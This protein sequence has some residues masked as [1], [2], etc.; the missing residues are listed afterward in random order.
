MNIAEE[1]A[2]CGFILK[3][4]IDE[5][6]IIRQIHIGD[7]DTIFEL[8]DGQKFLY[9]ELSDNTYI[10]RSHELP[11]LSKEEWIKEFSRKLIN[12]MGLRGVSQ[13]ELAQFLNISDSSMSRLINGKCNIDVY[14]VQRI[15]AY[16]NCTVSDLTN[17]DYLL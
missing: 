15:A 17:F 8:S 7:L 16:L 6:A 9:D 12:K 13:K 4:R 11:Y 14:L 2:R 5:S 3:N 1:N 10:I